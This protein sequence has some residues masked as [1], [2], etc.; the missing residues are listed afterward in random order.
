MATLTILI[1]CWRKE[2]EAQMSLETID[3]RTRNRNTFHFLQFNF[4][5][6]LL[7]STFIYNYCTFDCT[8]ITEWQLNI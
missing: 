1:E 8:S 5:R 7:L 3:L 6:F 4:S 2:S